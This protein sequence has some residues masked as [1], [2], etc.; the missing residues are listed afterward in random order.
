MADQFNILDRT[1]N[2]TLPTA[3][4]AQTMDRNQRMANLGSSLTS[5]TLRLMEIELPSGLLVTS[6]TTFSGTSGVTSPTAQWFG[7][8]SSAFATLRLT[9]DDGGGAWAAN[10]AKTLNLASPF[11]T[12]YSGRHYI[13]VNVTA[14]TPPTLVGLE[15]VT[16]IAVTA[17]PIMGG[18]S[19]TGLTDPA[20]CPATVATPTTCTQLFYAYV[21]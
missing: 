20:S 18:A 9:P 14:G 1:R 5:G 19:S 17:A 16:Q 7:L 8:F 15:T 21:S 11:T 6:I 12:T 2:F 13:G 4:L 3:A 10:T